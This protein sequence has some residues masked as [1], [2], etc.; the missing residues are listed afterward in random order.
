MVC[1]LMVFSPLAR[2]SVQGWAV[3]TIHLVSL[4]ALTALLINKSLTWQWKWIRTPLDKPLLLL[5]ILVILST[6]LS[7]HPR[8]SF[9]A[10]VLLINYIVI[11]YTAIHT[12]NT[13]S[14][15][16][17]ICGLIIGVAVFLS[18]FGIFKRFGINPF[19][20][21][22]YSDLHYPKAFLSS[23]YGNHNHLAGYLEMVIPVMIGMLF[24]GLN[25]GK[26]MIT[27]YLLL[28]ILSAFVL[29]LSRG[30]WISM[31]IGTGFIVGVLLFDQKFR[32]RTILLSSFAAVTAIIILVFISTPVTERILT[33]TQSNEAAGLY[34]RAM[35]WKEVMNVIKDH[36][37][38][39]TGPGTFGL[40]FTQY[41]PPGMSV[42]FYMA[43]ND[44]LH[45][46][47]ETGLLI[48]PVMVWMILSIYHRNFQKLNHTSRLIR[49]TNFGAV[50]GITAIL[51]HSLVDFNLHI[52]A[53]ALLF[54]ILVVIIVVPESGKS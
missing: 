37:V 5:V 12:I 4:L 6:I 9:W 48:I 14:R 43:H 24:T 26:F 3:N 35:V 21:W 40:I 46:I 34:S 18:V 49:Y 38:I 16:R 29:T 23:T 20:W 33:M 54:T 52:P 11:F 42:R 2:G 47:S 7:V 45:F 36:P 13:R 41:Q 10:L 15:L 31:F 1:G 44:Y 28:I 32:Y 30:G 22:D 27:I 53:N 17:T 19:P 51:V 25:R 8:T 50:G 39:G